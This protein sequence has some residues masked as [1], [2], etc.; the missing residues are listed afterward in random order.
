MFTRN[1]TKSANYYNPKFCLEQMR[2]SVWPCFNSSASALLV[3]IKTG[4]K[5][6]RGEERRCFLHLS[7]QSSVRGKE[8]RGR[9]LLEAFQYSSLPEVLVL[10]R[11]F[12]RMRSWNQINLRTVNEGLFDSLM[13]FKLTVIIQIHYYYFQNFVPSRREHCGCLGSPRYPSSQAEYIP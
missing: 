13:I 6:A 4:E 3:D 12:L 5:A 9:Q 8:G 10:F 7:K 2:C 11:L 1:Q